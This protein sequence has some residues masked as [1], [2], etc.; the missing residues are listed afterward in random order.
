MR[1]TSVAA[2]EIRDEGGGSRDNSNQ[3]YYIGDPISWSANVKL[4]DKYCPL[5]R[6]PQYS[7]AI[8]GQEYE[9]SD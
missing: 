8:I 4:Y 2:D 6:G 3:I 7:G 5:E 9:G 1:R